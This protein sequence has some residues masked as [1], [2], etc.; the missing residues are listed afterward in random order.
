MSDFPCTRASPRSAVNWTSRPAWRMDHEEDQNFNFILNISF[1]VNAID[2]K[3]APGII[4]QHE[5]A[6]AAP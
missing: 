1:L 3:A 6:A 5:P 2:H 4:Y